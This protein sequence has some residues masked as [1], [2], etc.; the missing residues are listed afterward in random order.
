MNTA[1]S[2]ASTY[3]PLSA[4]N[5]CDVIVQIVLTV[6]ALRPVP[7]SDTIYPR[8]SET[9]HER[10]VWSSSRP[11]FRTEYMLIVMATLHCSVLVNHLVP[12]RTTALVNVRMLPTSTARRTTLALNALRLSAFPASV[13][14]QAF[15]KL[16]VIQD[17]Q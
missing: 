10:S 11:S 16:V 3:S 15:A 17:S 2:I 8:L 1:F 5:A 7:T 6:E 4:T 9:P 12:S 14:L 13:T